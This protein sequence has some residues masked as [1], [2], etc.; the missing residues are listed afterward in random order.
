MD[1]SFSFDKM[2]NTNSTSTSE[3]EVQK[4]EHLEFINKFSKKDL[5]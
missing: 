1:S 4:E 3:K 2:M 5:E